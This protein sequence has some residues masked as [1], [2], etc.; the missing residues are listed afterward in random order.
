MQ[1]FKNHFFNTTISAILCLTI[2][3]PA[4]VKVLHAFENHTHEVCISYETEHFH[5]NDIDCEFYKFKKSGEFYLPVFNEKL[6]RIEEDQS[7]TIYSSQESVIK[8]NFN[9]SLRAPPSF[10]I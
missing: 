2:A 4:I 8:Q 9:F 10:L 5:K 6:Q 3:L 1:L 7:I